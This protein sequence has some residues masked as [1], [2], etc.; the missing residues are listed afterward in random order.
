M[1]APASPTRVARAPSAV[2]LGVVIAIALLATT[3]AQQP[4]ATANAAAIAPSA[5]PA[6]EA[7]VKALSAELRCLVCQNQTVA[8]SD[9]PVAADL[10]AQVRTQLAA[11]KSEDEVKQYMTD[12]FGDFVLYRP[13]LK[14]GTLLLWFGPPLALIVAGVLLLRR[15]RRANDA[16]A[17]AALSDAER[18]RAR[19]LLGEDDDGDRATH[20]ERS[21]A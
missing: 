6:L 5:D 20:D 3:H 7:R 15:L 12:R 19:A 4:T 9:A 11:G 13:P 1:T 2:A 17:V 16:P 21:R 10:R 8:D 14:A 18:A